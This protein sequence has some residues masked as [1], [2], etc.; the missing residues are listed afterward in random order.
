M[1]TGEGSEA[2]ASIGAIAIDCPDP[3]ALARFYADLLGVP[4][5]FMSENFA[6]FKA[7]GL[8]VAMHR[9]EDYRPPKWPDPLAPRQIHL[10][11]AVDD[12][13][14][15]KS[16]AIELGASEA[17]TQPAPDRWLVMVDPA[18]HPFCLSPRSAF[19]D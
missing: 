19:P 9:V 1:T 12:V 7:Q 18:G 3:E 17:H 13:Q 5:G 8:W 10:D 16:R 2:T 4:T 6:A 11:I 15:A 14:V